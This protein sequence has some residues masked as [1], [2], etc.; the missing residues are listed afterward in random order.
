M[1]IVQ[2]ARRK[3]SFT[4]C[5]HPFSPTRRASGQR[6]AAVGR[7]LPLMCMQVGIFMSCVAIAAVPALAHA[8]MALIGS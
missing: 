1:S 5:D 2:S 4:A 3:A 6:A 8:L 7:E